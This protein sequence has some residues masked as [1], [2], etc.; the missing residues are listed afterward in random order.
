MLRAN[1]CYGLGM[2]EQIT[3]GGGCFWCLEAVY[4]ELEGVEK[5]ESGYMGGQ[6]PDPTY[7]EVC[8][9]QSGHIEV[10][11]VTFD[12]AITSV[13]EILEVFFVIHDPTTINRQGNDAGPQYASAIF[14][15]SPE[16]REIAEGIIADLERSK[17]FADPIVTQ[18]RE[19]RKF[20]VAESYHQNYYR[21]NAR[22]S[23]CMYVVA[24]KLEKFRKT[25]AI[26]RRKSG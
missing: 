24:P 20:Y 6:V 26:K 19:A 21:D 3:L 25:F 12:P 11:Q 14:Y 17:A 8:G 15:H 22:K 18:V 5:V 2:T 10:V 4:Q 7:E 13:S 9:G 1:G 16:Q 23:Y